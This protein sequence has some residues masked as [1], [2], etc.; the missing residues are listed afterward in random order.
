MTM[1]QVL[2]GIK[3]LGERFDQ[4][5]AR[6]AA[7]ERETG[8]ADEDDDDDEAKKKA[9]EAM[10]DD[11]DD[12]DNGP[13]PVHQDARCPDHDQGGNPQGRQGQG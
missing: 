4:H 9:E 5:S 3:G 12:D 1:Q 13:R 10:A 8:M 6:L 2:E 7:L 11:D